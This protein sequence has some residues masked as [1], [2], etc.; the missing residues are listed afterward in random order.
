MS[1]IW[2]KYYKTNDKAILHWIC[3]LGK[4]IFSI[5]IINHYGEYSQFPYVVAFTNRT[6]SKD[7]LS[8]RIKMK[9]VVDKT[10]ETL[11]SMFKEYRAAEKRGKADEF[12][13]IKLKGFLPQVID[14]EDDIVTV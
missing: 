8:A 10:N 11:R 1:F 7:A 4:T 2:L 9:D 13:V 14:G 5:D 6:A 3:G 12:E